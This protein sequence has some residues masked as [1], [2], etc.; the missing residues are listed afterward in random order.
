LRDIDK[1]KTFGRN[2]KMLAPAHGVV[3]RSKIQE[4]TEAMTSWCKL[5][6]RRKITVVYGSMYGLT[7][8][9]AHF[10][11]E[12]L[13]EK[14]NEVT[15]HDA[16]VDVVNSILSDIVDSAGILFVTPTYEAN[17]FPPIANLIELLRIK[18][19]G[20]GKHAAAVVTKLWGGNAPALMASRLKE[21]A[22]TIYEPVHEFLNYPSEQELVSIRGF[23]L[24]FSEA[25]LQGI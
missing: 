25:A 9:F 11:V 10:A 23:L 19:L 3:Y 2:I 4:F 13:K 7:E 16:T 14:V 20:E 17:I 22:C 8:R 18:K 21:A 12:V 15:L 5:E 24:K 6:K 1:V